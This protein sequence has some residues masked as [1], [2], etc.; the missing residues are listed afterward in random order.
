MRRLET[1]GTAVEESN[2]D[3][4]R[5]DHI[6][7]ETHSAEEAEEYPTGLKFW[8]IILTIS[9]LVALGGLDTNIVAT[10][11]PRYVLEVDTQTVRECI[12]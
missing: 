12:S 10:A 2:P 8:L 3:P 11:V 9:A 5:G 4:T 7:P 1:N 6:D